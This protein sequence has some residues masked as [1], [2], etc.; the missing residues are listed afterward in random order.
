MEDHS[1]DTGRDFGRDIQD[2]KRQVRRRR[3]IYVHGFDPASS[4]R[5]R[6]LIARAGSNRDGTAPT[7]TAVG[8]LSPVSEGWRITAY[9]DNEPTETVFEVLR[10]ED[11]V[12]HWRNRPLPV[13]FWTGFGSWARFAFG[14][15]LAR[16]FRLAKGPAGLLFY[17]VMMLATFMLTGLF[18]GRILGEGAETLGAPDWSSQLGR[19]IGLAV[20]LWFSLR[21]ERAFFAHLM[22]ALFDFLIRVAEGKS[23]AGR[24]EARIEAFADRI[25]DCVAEANLTKV[26]EILIIGHSLGGLVATHTLARAIQRDV[27]LAQG[28]A[29]ISFLTLGSVAGFIACRGGPGADDLS[30]STIRIATT[31]NLYW[32]DVSAPRDWFSFGLVDPLLLSDAVPA[33]A[34]SPRVISAKFGSVTP[35]P[36]DRRT[37]FRAMGLHMKYLGAPDRKGGFDFFAVIAGNQTLQARYASRR[38]SPKARMLSS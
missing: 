37:R 35:D 5:Y 21:L 34:Q 20:G 3:V 14:G 8:P 36:D 16:A 7:F 27:D 10:Y 17:P 24:L 26:D 4:D 22:L 12:R 19:V 6:R 9:L 13:R 25:V 31:E 32:V 23:P 33:T 2:G 11:V 18:I 28:R 15:G 29:Q 30:R 38:N 1:Q